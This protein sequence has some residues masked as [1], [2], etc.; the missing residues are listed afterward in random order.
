MKE[1]VRGFVDE[2]V[3]HKERFEHKD[4]ALTEE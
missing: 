1:S 2:I 3:P 4:Y